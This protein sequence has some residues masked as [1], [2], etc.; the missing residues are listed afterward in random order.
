MKPLLSLLP[1]AFAA[2]ASSLQ[3]QEVQMTF[4]GLG[5][6]DSACTQEIPFVVSFDLNTLS[7]NLQTSVV[8][9]A[10]GMPSPGGVPSVVAFNASNM[11]VTNFF[12]SVSG[13]S[14]FVASTTGALSGLNGAFGVFTVGVENFFWD[15]DSFLAY[16][17][18][19]AGFTLENLLLAGNGQSGFALGFLSQGLAATQDIKVLGGTIQ[20][21]RVPEPGVLA[22]LLTGLAC[23][24]LARRVRLRPALSGQLG[25][26]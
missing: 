13:N 1:I 4:N 14:A 25:Q 15:G 7:G 22:L 19:A 11:A 3:A 5:C 12:E 18:P 17:P 8:P 6:L 16:P 9:F 10:N 23:L 21:T 24:G 2:A 26:L 20:V